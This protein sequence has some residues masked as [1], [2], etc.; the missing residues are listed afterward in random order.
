MWNCIEFWVICMY[1]SFFIDDNI[2]WICVSASCGHRNS[3]VVGEG[4]V[5]EHI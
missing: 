4:T 2:F 3:A 5:D 1:N